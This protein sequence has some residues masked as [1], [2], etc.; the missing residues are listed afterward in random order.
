[1]NHWFVKF[2]LNR[3]WVVLFAKTILAM[4][5]HCNGYVENL[6]LRCQT[7]KSVE[8]L[9]GNRTPIV[10]PSSTWPKPAQTG[11]NR[12]KAFQETQGQFKTFFALVG[13][14]EKGG[15]GGGGTEQQKLDEVKQTLTFSDKKMAPKK[16]ASFCWNYRFWWFVWL[17]TTFDTSEFIGRSGSPSRQLPPVQTDRV[18]IPDGS[19]NLALARRQPELVMKGTHQLGV[20][21]WPGYV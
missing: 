13:D 9:S 7:S 1:M 20:S 12:P 17:I 16:S 5:L 6:S 14:G 15:R 19:L 21:Y 18:W 8:S 11:P 4:G 2:I 3:L 10:S